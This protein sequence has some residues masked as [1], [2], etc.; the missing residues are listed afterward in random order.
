[1]G[2]KVL[3]ASFADEYR[4]LSTVYMAEFIKLAFIGTFFCLAFLVF[5]VHAAAFLGTYFATVLVYAAVLALPA[6]RS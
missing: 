6:S 5:K 3:S 4:L 2:R 1:M